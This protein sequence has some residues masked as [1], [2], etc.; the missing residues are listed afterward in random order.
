MT[1]NNIKKYKS[2]RPD[3]IDE[4]TAIYDDLLY[5]I[6]GHEGQLRFSTTEELATLQME[7]MNM[8]DK[9]NPWEIVPITDKEQK[10]FRKFIEDN[11]FEDETRTYIILNKVKQQEN[12]GFVKRFT[13]PPYESHTINMPMPSNLERCS[14]IFPK[15]GKLG[16]GAFYIDG[17]YKLVFTDP[18]KKDTPISDLVWN[19]K[20]LFNQLYLMINVIERARKNPS[21]SQEQF[22]KNGLDIYADEMVFVNE[23][24]ILEL[25]G[26]FTEKLLSICRGIYGV[27]ENRE[28][29][30]LAQKEGLI[31]SADAFKEYMN[32][33]NFIRHQWDTL[34]SFGYFSAE[35]SSQIKAKRAERVESYLNLCDQSRIKRMT[36]YV[37]ILHQMQ[38]VINQIN[39]NR[40]IR[41]NDE[42]NSRFV[43]RL[44][45][46]YQY[47]PDIEVELNYSFDNERFP[48]LNR[49]VHK[50][51]PDMRVVDDFSN[52]PTKQAEIDEYDKR[53][54]YLQ[55]FLSIECMVM[56]HC[57]MRGLDMSNREAWQYLEEIGML[58]HE[59][60]WRWRKYSGLRNFLSHN[61]FNDNLRMQLRI[62]NAQYKQDLNILMDR[63]MH[64]G[65]DVRQLER[66][67]CSYTDDDGLEVILD[68]D[69]HE[70]ISRKFLNPPKYERYRNGVEFN[71]SDR[72]IINVKLPNGVRVDL[73]AQTIHWNP[74][75]KWDFKTLQTSLNKIETDKS[76]RVIS[77]TER[78][79][80]MPFDRGDKMLVDYRHN[81]ILDSNSRIKE[82]RFRDPQNN[83]LRTCFAYTPNEIIVMFPDKTMV[84]KSGARLRVY[85]NG[86][87][88]NLENRRDFVATYDTPETAPKKILHH[89]MQ[90][91]RIR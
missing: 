73:N 80:P 58:S 5:I 89:T 30:E 88:L 20:T 40:I 8:F 79:N 9:N 39:P 56:R 62:K 1:M 36:S 32:I 68:H 15:D 55:T 82:F 47:K 49:T 67:I 66:N 70:I 86:K 77:C 17:L 44:K 45:A 61:Y 19:S 81:L 71:R 57:I 37:E 11:V 90:H 76:L 43:D 69:K 28:A 27:T 85:H 42:S 41:Y 14:I 52:S 34:D 31:Q 35:K 21:E 63:L 91:G 53:S 22:V 48:G 33:R 72:E 64:N 25:M 29:A 18:E 7:S 16:D 10:D 6:R 4:L 83:V 26:I 46:A 13:I 65:P 50:L 51:F 12:R 54:Y 75:T 87:F 3:Q 74:L 59:E 23:N 60:A 24:I 84:I 38:H 78:N 2:M